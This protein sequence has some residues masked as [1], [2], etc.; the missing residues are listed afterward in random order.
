MNMDV[1]IKESTLDEAVSLN[2][3]IPEFDEPHFTKV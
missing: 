3:Q 1:V 2:K